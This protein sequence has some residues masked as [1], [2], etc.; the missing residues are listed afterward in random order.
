[1]PRPAALCKPH[2]KHIASMRCRRQRMSAPVCA[3]RRLRGGRGQARRDEAGGQG[4]GTRHGRAMPAA[5]AQP[6]PIAASRSRRQRVTDVPLGNMPISLGCDAAE[7]GL[8]QGFRFLSSR[9]CII[10]AERARTEPNVWGATGV[11][12]RPGASFCGG[13]NVEVLRTSSLQ[14]LALLAR[15]SRDCRK[16][17]WSARVVPKSAEHSM[18]RR[19]RAARAEHAI[20]R[21]TPRQSHGRQGIICPINP[22]SRAGPG[23]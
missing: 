17:V 10:K 9:G 22:I 19:L 15:F 6:K 3:R 23:N 11:P 21:L 14:M 2:V 20:R 16:R 13:C 18:M 1:M 4:T 12:F 8:V 7:I 5:F